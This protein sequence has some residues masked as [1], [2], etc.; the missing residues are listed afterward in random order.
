VFNQ[1]GFTRNGLAEMPAPPGVTAQSVRSASG[2]T[3][4]VQTTAEGKLLFAASVQSLGYETYYL[5]NQP[6]SGG[7]V[8]VQVSEAG[9][10]VILTSSQLQ[11]TL[12]RE[13]GWA[14]TSLQPIV[15]GQLQPD[16][17][18]AGQTANA[19]TFYEDGGNIYNF[20]NEFAASGLSVVAGTLTSGDAQVVE[21]G[22]LR[23]RVAASVTFSQGTSSATYQ[24]EYELIDGEPFLR[25]AVTGAA[26]LPPDPSQGG[27]PYAVMVRFPFA[28]NGQA[29]SI[30]GVLRGTP[31]H[32]HDELPVA[33][34]E[35]PTFQATHH[36]VVPS[37]GGTTLGALYHADVPAWAIDDDGAMIG[38]ILRNTPASGAWPLAGEN[39]GANGVDFG[40]HRRAYALRIP[41]GL[42]LPAASPAIFEESFS[43]ATPL[44]GA[45]VNVPSDGVSPSHPVDVQL[46][47]SFSLAGVTSGNA[48]LTVAK[49]GQ[50]DPAA[51]I[52]RLYQPSNTSQTVAL[53]LAG[54]LTTTGASSPQILPVTALEQAIPGTTA[55]PLVDGGV[56]LTMPNALAT[57][58]I[59]AS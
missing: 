17:V 34:W 44:L 50:F 20:G 46:P 27:T 22:G 38:C 57:L 4:P 23:A 19:L 3:G 41:Q 1:L 43:Y 5:S 45:I 49:A 48:I 42:D 12:A 15:G 58:S 59:T 29:A 47:P 32:W 9:D 14:L 26:P 56:S 53:S 40:I 18:P 39:R 51:L 31:Y 13:N 35:G 7:S 55:L 10:Q 11:A 54:Y 30:D 24:V 8:T 6:A 25:M 28:A 37:A 16:L 36:F 52:L 2:G 33:Y 21:N